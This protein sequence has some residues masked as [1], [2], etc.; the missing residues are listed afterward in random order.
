MLIRMA[1]DFS[2][3]LIGT[4]AGGIPVI[5]IILMA[6]FLGP[7]ISLVGKLFFGKKKSTDTATN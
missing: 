3:I 1:W 2:A 4:L 6:V 7:V 5:G